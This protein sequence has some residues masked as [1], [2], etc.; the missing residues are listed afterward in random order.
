LAGTLGEAFIQSKQF[1]NRDWACSNLVKILKI[2]PDF[3]IHKCS[4][5][6]VFLRSGVLAHLD[7]EREDRLTD[8]VVQLQALCRGYLARKQAQKLKVRSFNN[9]S[10]STHYC[11]ND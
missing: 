6:Q 1:S 10:L 4:G 7:E 11:C 8:Q 2:I 3:L 5:F 9:S